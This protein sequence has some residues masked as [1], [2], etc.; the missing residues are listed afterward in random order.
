MWE[1]Y[2]ILDNIISPWI[3]ND[4]TNQTYKIVLKIVLKF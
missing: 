2:V 4:T 1:V 3:I